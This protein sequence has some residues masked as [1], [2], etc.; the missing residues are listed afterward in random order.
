LYQL[1]AGLMLSNCQYRVVYIVD[2]VVCR[3]RLMLSSEVL[4][5]VLVVAAA[6]AIYRD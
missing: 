5:I 4:V 6:A 2:L 1:G 3:D